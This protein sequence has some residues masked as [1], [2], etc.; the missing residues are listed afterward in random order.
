MADNIR[1]ADYFYTTVPDEPGEGYRIL[2]RLKEAGVSLL[3]FSA[4]P[5]AGGQAQVD[6]VPSDT[7][8]F[9]KAA[10]ATGITLS[11]RKRGF[12]IDGA[13]R[14]GAVAEVVQRLAAA[15]INITAMDALC[16]GGGRYGAILWVK[17]DAYETA[18]KT[19]GV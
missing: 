8:K 13:D 4:F 15:K 18:A 14:P 5:M 9:L 12:L 2:G 3:A 16:A 11:E 7:E 10:K 17:P 19:L 6:F 1:R